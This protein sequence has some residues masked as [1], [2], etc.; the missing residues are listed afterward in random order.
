MPERQPRSGAADRGAQPIGG[1]ALKHWPV[2]GPVFARK[3]T[4]TEPLTGTRK[5][6]LA[7]LSHSR[8]C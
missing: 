4:A 1:D 6:A 5:P 2:G 3:Q 7:G 8:R